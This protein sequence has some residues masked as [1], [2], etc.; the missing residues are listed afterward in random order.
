MSM[1]P[2][3]FE[4]EFFKLAGT[5]LSA[6]L[7]IM[8]SG[9]SVDALRFNLLG[10]A[11]HAW[12]LAALCEEMVAPRGTRPSFLDWATGVLTGKV[13][14]EDGSYIRPAQAEKKENS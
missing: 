6:R 13:P 7:Q 1:K 3:A 8:Q 2:L 10:Y 9:P 12:E 4:R 14:L 11:D 5:M